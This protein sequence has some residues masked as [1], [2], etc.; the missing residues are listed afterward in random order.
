[1]FSGFFFV[2]AVI[3]IILGIKLRQIEEVHAV[4]ATSAGLLSS[5]CSFVIAPPSVQL[6]LGLSFWGLIHFYPL[7]A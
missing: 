1:M 6:L 7:R 3:C 2:V 5:F 4:A